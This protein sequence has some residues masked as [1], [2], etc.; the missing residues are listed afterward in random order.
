MS[1]TIA[2]SAWPLDTMRRLWSRATGGSPAI[3]SSNPPKPMTALSGVRISWLMLARKS[4]LARAAASAATRALVSRV[5]EWSRSWR[6]ASSISATSTGVPTMAGM[7]S[8]RPCRTTCMTAPTWTSA[9]VAIIGQR[10]RIS[11]EPDLKSLIRIANTVRPV[12]VVANTSAMDCP[13]SIS[14]MAIAP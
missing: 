8:G 1:F 6:R 9:T 4:A 10:L 7:S 12:R 2:S 14:M 5:R 3:P 13:V 11:L